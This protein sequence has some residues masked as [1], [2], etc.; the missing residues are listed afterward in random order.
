M[1]PR[2]SSGVQVICPLEDNVRP[3]GRI[4]SASKVSNCAGRSGS[5]ASNGARNS[6]PSFASKVTS[7][8]GFGARFTSVTLI[9]TRNRLVRMGEPL[10]NARTRKL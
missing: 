9:W 4:P 7:V 5:V 1:P 8:G 3:A 6:T 10:S 2:L